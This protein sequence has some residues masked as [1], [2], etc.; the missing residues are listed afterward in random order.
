MVV[1]GSVA[2]L[3][4]VNAQ[5]EGVVEIMYQT[6]RVV[7]H[8]PSNGVTEISVAFETRE[9]GMILNVTPSVSSDNRTINLTVIPEYCREMGWKKEAQSL[10]DPSS[11]LF[12]SQNLTT[13]VIVDSGETVVLGGGPDT[14]SK[15]YS[16]WYFSAEI[17]DAA[18]RA[19]EGAE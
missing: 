5:V 12:H 13:T 10:D 9:T 8:N 6:E 16:Y 18:G 14:E 4:N 19:L 3:N 1:Q 15:G 2:T 17:V 11:P 7:D